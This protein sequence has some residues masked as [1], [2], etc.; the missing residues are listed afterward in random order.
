MGEG[1]FDILGIYTNPNCTVAQR[2][3][4]LCYV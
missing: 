2:H 1:E 4:A 3:G